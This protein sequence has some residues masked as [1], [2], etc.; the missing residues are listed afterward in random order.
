MAN[1]VSSICKNVFYHQRSIGQIRRKITY[2]A[3]EKLIYALVTSRI[4]YGNS[5]LYGIQEYQIDRLQML[6]RITA[7]ILTLSHSSC[8]ISF[9]TGK[10]H[11]LSVRER[12]DFKILL[13]TLK[14]QHGLAPHYPTELLLSQVTKKL[15]ISEN[16]LEVQG[17]Q[18]TTFGNR[19][20]SVAAP[21]L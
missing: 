2:D 11:W 16:I 1:Q 13:L 9:I 19:A 21:C 17:T 7:R 5:C 14:A 15:L 12:I 20:F 3:C 6:F 8:H 18:T 10:L 4:D